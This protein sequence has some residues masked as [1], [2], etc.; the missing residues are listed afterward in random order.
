VSSGEFLRV[1][2]VG[3]EPLHRRLAEFNR[4]RLAPRLTAADWQQQLRHE[5]ELRV[6]EGHFLEAARAQV[7]EAARKAP[8][9]PPDFI[10]W[11]DSLRETGASQSEPF[12]GWL[13]E[14]A[15]RSEMSWFLAQELAGDDDLE[16]LLALAQL[17]QP[18]RAKIEIARNYWDEMGQGN[19]T[20]T[21]A[22][23][24]VEL[25]HDLQMDSTQPP[26][27]ESL[28]RAN[29]ML[30]LAT[31][32]GYAFQALGALGVLEM[33]TAISARYLI[34]GLRRLGFSR[35]SCAY[36]ESRAKLSPLRARAWNEDVI[37]PLV[38][39]DS[40]LAVAVAEGAL[41][42]SMADARCWRRYE[43]ELGVFDERA[44]TASGSM[45][46]RNHG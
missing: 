13:E 33:T 37:L 19:A 10:R 14:E 9:Q 40:R 32:R 24:L 46:K 11:L 2:E 5:T 38:A 7:S 15:T 26:A 17:R 18:W 36:F 29:L 25:G 20:A 43:R 22:H 41:M 39:Q 31:N 45:P 35:A 4:L 42:R 6:V 1:G 34:A 30:G 8:T 23:L 16:D 12:L 44:S 27:W 3:L 21:G 28:A